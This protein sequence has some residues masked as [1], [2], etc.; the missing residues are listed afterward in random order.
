MSIKKT[1]KEVK[2]KKKKRRKKSSFHIMEKEIICHYDLFS[3]GKVKVGNFSVQRAA[4]LA[5]IC[6]E[7]HSNMFVCVLLDQ[8][9]FLQFFFYLYNHT[10]T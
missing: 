3:P 10:N 8:Y 7:Q 2:K 4:D 9:T 5:P 6:G 1:L